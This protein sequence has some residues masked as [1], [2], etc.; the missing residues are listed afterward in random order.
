MLQA[1]IAACMQRWQCYSSGLQSKLTSGGLSIIS[2]KSSHCMSTQLSPHLKPILADWIKLSLMIVG[3]WEW[4]KRLS[5]S[6]FM[7]HHVKYLFWDKE[8]NLNTRFFNLGIILYCG[9]PNFCACTN[10]RTNLQMFMYAQHTWYLATIP[11]ISLIR[12]KWL[13][14]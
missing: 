3:S 1:I 10:S 9:T 7:N 6:S 11:V 4:E 14:G 5:Q 2:R 12:I 8:F 13:K